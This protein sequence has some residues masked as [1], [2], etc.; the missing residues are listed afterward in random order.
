MNCLSYTSG[1]S[2]NTFYNKLIKATVVIVIVMTRRCIVTAGEFK[3]SRNARRLGCCMPG[4]Y[5]ESTERKRKGR[6][7]S[8]GC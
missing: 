7:I 5:C 6:I 3:C 8:Q 4:L 1:F 2:F